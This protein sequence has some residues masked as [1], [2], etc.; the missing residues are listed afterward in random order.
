MYCPSSVEDER[1]GGKFMQGNAVADTAKKFCRCINN[2]F[3][4]EWVINR[5]LWAPQAPN[6]DLCDLY[7]TLKEELS[8]E[9]ALGR[10]SRKY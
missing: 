6:L 10:T 7:G 1:S 8:E 2:E 4:C 3:F 5:E 9:S